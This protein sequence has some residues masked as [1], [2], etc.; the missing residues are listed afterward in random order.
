MEYVLQNTN[1]NIEKF[2]FVTNIASS[3]MFDVIAEKFKANLVRTPIGEIFLVEK[4]NKM[5]ME[6]KNQT[7][8]RIIF[9][10]EGS[11]G[12]VMFPLFNNTRDGIFAAAK[13]VEILINTGEK[14]SKL[15]SKLPKFYSHREIINIERVNIKE[16]IENIRKTLI[17]EGEEVSRIEN[18][19]KFGKEKEWFALIHPSNTEPILRVIS[20]AKS[21]SLSRLYCETTTELIK[22]AISKRGVI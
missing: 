5:L 11:C 10:G 12:G 2:I 13:I 14:I 9:G 17:A 1:Q 22:L 20:E 3:L 6:N 15:V 16:L 7:N 8:E 4:I 21:D 18:D 19:L